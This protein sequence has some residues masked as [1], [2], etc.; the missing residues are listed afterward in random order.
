MRLIDEDALCEGKVDNDPV[1][2]EVQVAPII[3]AV[4]V[5][6]C[7]DCQYRETHHCYMEVWRVYPFKPTRD[8]DFCSYGK[9]REEND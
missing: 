4:P 6:R 1:V 7:K 2:I 5:V 3:D 9:R 8:N